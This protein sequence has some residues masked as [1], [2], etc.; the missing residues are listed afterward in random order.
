VSLVAA[1]CVGS[2][3]LAPDAVIDDVGA[4]RLTE[5]DAVARV[6]AWAA[7]AEEVSR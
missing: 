6:D 4:A 1:R 5:K 7:A 3:G 2:C